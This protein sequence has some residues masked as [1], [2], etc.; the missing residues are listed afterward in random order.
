MKS[1]LNFDLL[2]NVNYYFGNLLSYKRHGSYWIYNS[3]TDNACIFNTEIDSH[4]HIANYSKKT[5]A[6]YKNWYP[7]K[8][9]LFDDNI[10]GLC[11]SFL[12]SLES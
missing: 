2:Y 4:Y 11:I 1:Y 8:R 6:S 10:D 5:N 9:K 7:S 12:N 3:S